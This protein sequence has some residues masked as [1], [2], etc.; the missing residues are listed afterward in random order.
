MSARSAPTPAVA[1][2]QK[3]RAHQDNV[4]RWL[5]PV[6][7]LIIVLVAVAAAESSPGPGR[8]GTGFWV[9]VAIGM[10]TAGALAAFPTR[11][12][13]T[14]IYAAAVSAAL[15]GATL[16]AWLQPGG[17]GLGA[18]FVAMALIARRLPARI[19]TTLAAAAVIILVATADDDP[20]RAVTKL[21]TGVAMAS[22]Y[23]VAVIAQRLRE[24]NIRAEKLLVELQQTRMVQ[25]QAAALAE[26]QRLAREIHDILAHTLSGLVLQLDAAR[27]MTDGGGTDSRL[28]DTIE[29]AHRLAKAGLDESRN[30]IGM[31]REDALPGPDQLPDLTEQ[32]Q[33]RTGV[34]CE[35]TVAG[36]Q[37][38]L[39]PQAR[40]AL[41]R[42]A[43]EALTNAGKHGRPARV[44]VHLDYSP[45]HA[46]L[47]VEDYAADGT[48]PNPPNGTGYGLTG[49]RERAELLGGSLTTASTDAGFR[50]ELHVRV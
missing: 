27:L 24:T 33:R 37:P 36:Q 3:V 43:Q 13:P 15:T 12:A 5:R 48:Q 9:A 4:L 31:L 42:V 30:A 40:L 29:R 6:G 14:V 32:F 17:P 45:D 7:P 23:A 21:L 19:G 39:D 2:L 10:F 26:R 41:Y 25:A 35:F 20:K 44:A 8:H 46:R 18:L 50:V 1:A 16:L 11:Y 22:F 47:T 34:P 49:M 28:P 38:A